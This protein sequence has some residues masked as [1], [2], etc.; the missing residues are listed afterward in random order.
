M[1]KKLLSEKDLLSIEVAR[2][3]YEYDKN[4]Q[5]IAKSLS[6]SRPTVSKLLK[7]AKDK[8]YITI[9]INSPIESH[10]S[11]E[12]NL[13][14]KFNLKT[15]K[16]AHTNLFGDSEET[17]KK[18]LGKTTAEYLADIVKDGS[19]IG[20]S[21]GETIYNVAQQLEPKIVN[22]VEVTQLK[23][24]MNLVHANTH[25]QEIMTQFV[26][27]FHAVGQYIP[28]PVI[29]DSQ[30]SMEALMKEKQMQVILERLNTLD[31][32]VYTIGHISEQSLV[33]QNEYITVDELATLQRT[34]VCDICSRFI[35]EHANPVIEELDSRT[36]GITIKQLKKVE[37]SILIASGDLKLDGIY[38]TL[39]NGVPNVLVTDSITAVKLMEY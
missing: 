19:R 35:D 3:Y 1:A 12:N 10:A 5:E 25:D 30:L 27:N 21:W 23:G 26:K 28:L 15:V 29:F 31:I 34:A 11:L 33:V 2:M 20:I 22:N 4:Q 37:N 17:I 7:H 32:A 8:Q 24:G 16:I 39:K 14:E 18:A 6:I 9:Q 13:K 36:F 38:T